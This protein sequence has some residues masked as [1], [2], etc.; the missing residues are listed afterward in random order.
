M[1]FKEYEQYVKA[2]F[3][4]EL[5][6]SLNK[7]IPINHL[8]KLMAPDGNEYEIDLNYLIELG[9]I[10]YHTIIECKNWN[11]RVERDIILTVEGK[12]NA[13]HAHK[14]IVVSTCG[15]QKGAIELAITNGIGLFKITTQGDVSMY[16]NFSGMYSDNKR[17]LEEFNKID[18]KILD[19]GY[20]IIS[21]T[22]S[23]EDYFIK[24]YNTQISE[25]L[26]NPKKSKIIMD[27]NPNCIDEY[28][29]IETGG[30]PLTLEN[31]SLIRMASLALHLS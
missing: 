16:S 19:G 14:A 8:E 17:L 31:E 23:L 21:P 2:Y 27:I 12:K 18:D 4:K 30:L 15:F 26:E 10:S 29:M 25:I 3:E 1:D 20:G 9:G 22:I 5:K 13:L 28:I 6:K 24:N 7:S 11:K